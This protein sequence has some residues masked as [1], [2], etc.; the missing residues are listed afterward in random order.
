MEKSYEPDFFAKKYAKDNNKVLFTFFRSDGYNDTV[1]C[2]YLHDYI[3][4]DTFWNFFLNI[5]NYEMKFY[6]YSNMKEKFEFR[7]IDKNE[8]DISDGFLTRIT[9]YN[10]NDDFEKKYCDIFIDMISK[11]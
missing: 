1:R 9:I 6:P 7:D 8:I 4:Y 2:F 10:L 3:D 5:V 11:I